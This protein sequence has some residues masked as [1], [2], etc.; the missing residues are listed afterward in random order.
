MEAVSIVTIKKKTPLFKGDEKAERIELIELEE[1]GFTLISQKDLYQIGDKAIYIQPDFNLSDIPLFESFLRPNGDATKSMLGKVNGVPLRI[2]AKKFNFSIEGSIDPVYSNGILLPSLEV[3]HY[4]TTKNTV[5]LIEALDKIIDG[6]VNLTEELGI[7]KWEEPEDNGKSGN[8]VGGS[9]PFPSGLYKTDE[10]NIN[11]VWSHIHNKI[12][13]PITLVG[14]EKVDGSS[15]TIGVKSGRGFIC[16]RNLEKPLTVKK[17][18][19]RR[20]KTFLEKLIFWK[21]HDLNIYEMVPNDDDFIKYGKPIIDTLKADIVY[22]DNHVIRGELNGGGLKGSGNKKNPAAKEQPNIKV[23]GIDV[24]NA[25]G[26]A[27]RVSYEYFKKTVDKLG[28]VTV[29]E[30]FN[31]EFESKEHLERVC[32]EYFKNNLIEGIVVRT[33]DGKFSAKFMNNHYDSLK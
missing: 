23:F 19:G 32:N 2:R 24:I 10:N 4:L 25:N 15:I 31:Q 12:G 17:Q 30:V 7:T 22:G 8:K 26:I 13:Y 21:N 3:I 20:N 5:S 16:S 27:E 9:K 1:N 28:L 18:V 33:L 11:N 29:T 14:T 6:E